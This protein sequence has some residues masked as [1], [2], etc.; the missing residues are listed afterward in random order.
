M[1]ATVVPESRR[2]KMAA[3]QTGSEYVR[4]VLGS[5]IMSH[6][7]ADVVV[8][9]FWANHMKSRL[10]EFPEETGG[11]IAGG[12][13]FLTGTSGHA[14]NALRTTLLNTIQ[15]ASAY[16]LANPGARGMNHGWAFGTDSRAEIAIQKVDPRTFP[17]EDKAMKDNF[18]EAGG[19]VIADT[20]LPSLIVSVGDRYS[21][22]R[23]YIDARQGAITP[24]VLYQTEETC[25]VPY[26]WH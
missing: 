6:I 22:L 24:Q 3:Y 5:R 11:H 21:S 1:G 17:G 9:P 18:I 14:V 12:L 19:P 4:D 2:G 13:V 10:S 25:L 20:A 8:N 15:T 23:D 26:G 7:D 16:G